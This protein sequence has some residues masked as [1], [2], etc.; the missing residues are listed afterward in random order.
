MHFPNNFGEFYFKF[1]KGNKL[2]RFKSD[3]KSDLCYSGFSLNLSLPSCTRQ[4][5]EAFVG[6][7]VMK[8]VAGGAPKNFLGI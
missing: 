7:P 8:R 3:S 5:Q 1:S 6:P 4:P 2:K